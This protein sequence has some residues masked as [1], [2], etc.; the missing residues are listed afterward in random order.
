[1]RALS[2]CLLLITQALLHAEDG[3]TVTCRFLSLDTKALPPMLAPSTGGA[4]AEL[5]VP[6]SA[7]SEPIACFSKT[8]TLTFFA[9]ADHK[10]L[11]TAKIPANIKS[12]ILC[13]VPA[14]TATNSLPWRIFIVENSPKNC[15]PGGVF[16]ANFHSQ[17]IRFVIGETKLILHPGS[18][19]GVPMPTKR[20]EGNMASVMFQFQKGDAWVGATDTMLRFLP[21]ISYFMFASMDATTGRP[22]VTS[23]Q[24]ID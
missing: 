23:F 8:D 9:A 12:A 14:G 2:I 11:A 1:M 6:T 7:L 16:V 3:I 22:Q 19:Y 17:D 4:E 13:F 5:I 24:N 15:P 21:R 10:P 20:N 18:T